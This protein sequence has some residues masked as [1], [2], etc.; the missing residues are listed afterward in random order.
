MDGLTLAATIAELKCIVGSRIDKIQQP[1]KDELLLTIHGAAGNKRLLISAS[2]DNYR[3]H[4][5]DEKQTSPIDAPMFLMILRKYLGSSRIVSIEQFHTDRIVIIG[6]EAVNEL[7]DLSRFRL[8]C[9]FMGRHSNIVLVDSND[10]VI[11]SIRRVTPAISTI[12]VVLPHVKYVFPPIQ[13]KLDPMQATAADFANALSAADR[14]E[15]ALCTKF[16]G[17]SPLV[18]GEL[19][20]AL[21]DGVHSIDELGERIA[22]FYCDLA[23]GRATPCIVGR[24]LGKP[25]YLLPFT[26]SAGNYRTFPSF[27]AAIE[28][29]YRLR[30][31]NE[32]IK[33]RTAAISH[34]ISSN[35]QRIER[36][37]DKFSLS[38]CDYSEIERLKLYGELLIAN[39]YSIRPHSDSA[40]VYN[41]YCDPPEYVEIPL[42]G[43]LSVFDNAQQY[44]KRYRKSKSAYSAAISQRDCALAELDYLSGVSASLE[45]CS[46]D[47]DLSE[48]YSELAEQGYIKP[49]QNSTRSKHKLPPSAPH[50]FISSDGITIFVGKNN[51]QNDLLTFKIASPSDLWL[52]AKDIHGSHV[53]IKFTND[54]PNRTLYEAAVLAAFY[55]QARLS[56]NVPIDYT[57]RKYVKKPSGAKPGMVIYTNQSTVYVAPDRQ[58]VDKLKR[59]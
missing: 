14:P 41:Y 2:P 37:I 7:Y 34:C 8:I 29:F 4:L 55:S 47:A 59:D 48:I 16:Y 3:I 17:L 12:R 50:R 56:G 30:A 20:D 53:I 11:D 51:R 58:L 57:L 23:A 21:G 43:A 13:E 15:K 1:Q 40:R 28:E 5:T 33:R 26:P 18:A 19:L 27:C 39:A 54:I 35:I 32:R 44:F 9:E 10:I 31:S 42:D 46:T 24:E 52:H 36:K 38:I 22:A 49:H 6:F 25:S 45:L